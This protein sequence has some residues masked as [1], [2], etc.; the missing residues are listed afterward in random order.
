MHLKIAPVFL[1]LLFAPLLLPAQSLFPIKKDKKW[2]LMNSD[3][4]LVQ[5]PVYDAIG[6][7]KQFGYAVMQRGGKVGMLSNKGA[8]VVPPEY[9]DLKVLDSTL[10]SV[11]SNGKWQVVNLE[12]RVILKPGYERVQVLN[13]G[14]RSRRSYLAFL[15]NKKW[16]IVDSYGRVVAVPKY[17]EA[18][19]LANVPEHVP[20]VFFQTVKDGLLGLLLPN[21][22][23]A[24]PPQAEE[25][26]IYSDNLFFFK[27]YRKW[28]AIDPQGIEVL[29]AIFDHFSRLSENFIKLAAGNEACLFSQY[30]NKLVAQGG[31]EAYYPFSENFALCKRNR[32]LGLLDHCGNLVLKTVYNEIQPYGGDLFRANFKGKWGIVTL[33]DETLIP[34][35]YDYIA[36]MQKGLC[37]VIKDKKRGIAN[38]RGEVVVAPSFDVIELDE[39]KAKA[40]QRNNLSVFNFGQD[41]RLREES[42]FSKHFTIRITRENLR[43]PW[44]W[45]ES[46]SPYQLEKFEWFYSPQ[47]DKWGLRRLDNGTVQI[48]P[49]FDVVQVEMELGLTLVGI[50]MMQEMDY[51]RTSYRYEMAY[52]LVQND[53]GLLVHEVDMVDVRLSDFDRGLPVARCS[54]VN[55][56]QGLVTRIGKVIRKDFVFIGDFHDGVARASMKGKLSVTLSRKDNNLGRLQEF[57]VKQLAPVSLAD[58]T[59]HDLNVD[60]FGMLTCEDCAWGYLDTLGQMTVPPNYTFAK[61]FVNEVGIVASGEK[62]GLVDNAGKQL[63]PCK[64]D[65][66]GFLKDTGN[67]VLRVFKKEEKYGLIDTLGRLAVSVQYEG[68]GFF[69]EGLLAVKRNGYWGFVDPNGREVVPC[70][71]D[72]VKVFSE[73]LATARLGSKW[74]YIDKNGN[75]ELDF[76]FSKAGNFNNGL[77]PAKGDGPHYG[78]I[79]REG[80]WAIAPQF[81]R[82]HDF[83]RSVARV[84]DMPGEYFRTGFIDASGNYI[85]KPK[86]VS[87]TPFDAH[88]L[89]VAALGGNPMKYGLVNLKGQVITSKTFRKILPF[90]E[91]FA[92]VQRRD[93]YGFIDTTGQLVISPRFQ[94]VSDFSE[95][96]AAVYSEGRCGFIDTAGAWAVQPEYSRCMDFRDGKAIVFKGGQRAGLIDA[97]G[98]LVIEPGINRLLDFNDG[99]G[100]VRDEHYQFYYITEQA[101]FYDGFYEKASQFRHGVAVVQVDGRWAIINQQ[102]IEIIP[103]KY[104][105]IGQFENGFAKVRIKGFNG[106]T[107]LRGELIVRPD[108]EYISYAGEGLFR[109]EQGDKIGYFDMDGCWVWGLQD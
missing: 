11:M 108:Y 35:D 82:A 18:G 36:P 83:D 98:T 71:F 103:P 95:G 27:K 63:L 78:Y 80:N 56:R 90:S 87:V 40:Y 44:Q 76:V 91:G 59:L 54:F 105:K 1:V 88:G 25:I 94:K 66:L 60:K 28:G 13:P 61:D 49:S 77:A 64:F 102:G 85:V 74:G 52:G 99:R 26:R 10:I 62:W 107:N 33:E 109:V 38:F 14:S 65:E 7:F 79:G 106:L 67:K 73:G 2:G 19:L 6:E 30:Y 96:K 104:D 75:V 31:F 5:Q 22:F 45:E 70:R 48:E 3:G 16:G 51:D 72:E 29:A 46:D 93:G 4:Q 92:R 17:D 101:R 50:D 15:V 39:G 21:G 100:L 41:G 20:G 69:S 8:E 12:G 97:A 23:E 89:A 86:F 42:N 55:G 53:T 58:Y 9:D 84:E 34:F 81:P 57:L 37:V 68:I 24:L 32:L 43:R 47:D